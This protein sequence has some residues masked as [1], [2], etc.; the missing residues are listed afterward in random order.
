MSVF[1]YFQFSLRAGASLQGWNR[2][3]EE[4]VCCDEEISEYENV[5]SELL[6]NTRLLDEDSAEQLLVV[7]SSLRE[8]DKAL[9]LKELLLDSSAEEKVSIR[10]FGEVEESS[11]QPQ[12][13]IALAVYKMLNFFFIRFSFRRKFLSGCKTR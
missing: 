9:S 11:P 7:E 5:V 6:L 13:R 1:K 3:E 2:L 4:D 10:S 8:L 12:R